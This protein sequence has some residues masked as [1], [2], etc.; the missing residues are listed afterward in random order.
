MF[1]LQCY[2]E[3]YWNNDWGPI[4]V[5]CM[6]FLPPCRGTLEAAGEYV[7]IFKL[8]PYATC[9]VILLNKWDHDYLLGS[10]A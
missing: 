1:I 5:V 3:F 6:T 4:G 2:Q 10:Y 8:V 7:S 9:Y